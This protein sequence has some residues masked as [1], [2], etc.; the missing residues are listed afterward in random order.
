MSWGFQK[1]II[2]R[3]EEMSMRNFRRKYYDAFSKYYDRFVALHSRDAQGGLRKFL[4]AKIPVGT[5]DFV[6]DLCTGTGTLLPYLGEK[7]GENGLI[8][9]ADFSWGMLEVCNMKN[10]KFPNIQILESD[11]AYLPFKDNSFDAVTCSHAFYELKGKTQEQML[12]ETVRVL[13]P[14]KSFLMMEHDLPENPVIRILLYIRL[15]SMGARRALNTLKHEK[16][17]L[18]KHFTFVEKLETTT[19]RSKIIV[20]H[21]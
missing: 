11:V 8:V 19:G 3:L 9:G 13:K 4:S 6:L 18:E 12:Q 14:G 10:R 1:N 20:C 21:N 5:G 2:K 17:T 16:E 15:L 7:V